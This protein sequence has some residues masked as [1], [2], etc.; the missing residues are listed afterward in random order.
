MSVPG[1][2]VHA[3]WRSE[4]ATLGMW[5]FLATEVMFFGVLFFAAFHA[6]IH[7]PAG[8]AA[9]SHLTHAW[10]GT[11]NT[12]I[13]LTSSLTMALGVRASNM[14]QARAPRWLLRA[15]AALGIAFLAVKAAEYSL[16]WRDGLVPGIRFDYARPDARGVQSFFYLYFV[17]T[18]L[19]AV[20][21][22]IG[23]GAVSWISARAASR[24]AVE[25]TG[26][27]WHFVDVVWIFL[28]PVIYL[29][30]LWR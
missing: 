24:D 8:Y 27:Y 18:G 4:S 15:T 30:E 14:G 12:A 11:I 6:R 20:H 26:L 9:G 19:H 29:V 25:I 17:M 13:L 7:D 10:L 22:A 2:L 23:I 16:E 21:L 1:P 5:I 3:Q 28:Y